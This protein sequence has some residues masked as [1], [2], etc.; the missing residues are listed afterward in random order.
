M[1]FELL[2]DIQDVEVIAVNRS[3]RELQRF[4]KTYG[5]GRW[6]KL[7]GVATAQL[8]DGTACEAENHW[9]EAQGIGKKEFKIKYILE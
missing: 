4:K 3:I 1:N 8:E 2:S 7:K 6:R 5:S 9:Y